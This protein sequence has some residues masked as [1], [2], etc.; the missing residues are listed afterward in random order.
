MRHDS[1]ETAKIYDSKGKV[2]I[3][4][5]GDGEHVEFSPY[6]IKSV[7]KDGVL[8]H[9]HPIGG[10]FSPHDINMLR[11][12][13]LTEIRAITAEGVYRMQ[14]PLKWSKNIDSFDKMEKMYY[15]IDKEVS[16]D[17][18]TKVVNGELSFFEADKLMQEAAVKELCD[19]YDIP[20]RFDAWDDIR[21]DMK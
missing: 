2:L 12:G 18:M 17:I 1:I 8:T 10:C 21:G 13:K 15:D 3:S 5:S 6:E 14:K 4:K 9:N 11:R 7:M 16:T 20:F 19:R